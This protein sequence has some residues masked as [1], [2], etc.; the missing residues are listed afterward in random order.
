MM[1]NGDCDPGSRFGAMVRAYRREAGLTQK[2]LAAKARLSVAALRDIEQSRRHRPR[3]SSLAALADALGLD[4]EQTA[5]MF[6]AGRGMASSS[7]PQRSG[8]SAPADATTT[9]QGLWLA[10]L[11]PLHGW[12]DGTPLSFGPPAR[13]VVLGLLL[14]D[15]DAGV[16]RNTIVDT[17]WGERP[18]SASMRTCVCV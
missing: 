16:R 7:R 6:A 10:V 17:L 2:E 1:R 11:G 5:T 13:R 12:R 4:S 3:P 18:P 14:M 8:P 9:G 15:P